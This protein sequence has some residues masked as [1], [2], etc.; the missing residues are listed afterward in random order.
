MM[1]CNVASFAASVPH[2]CPHLPLFAACWAR[3]QHDAGLCRR[4]VV[5]RGVCVCRGV[6]VGVGGGRMRAAPR[7]GA[8]LAWSPC[9]LAPTGTPTVCRGWLIF[10]PSPLVTQ[11]RQDVSPRPVAGLGHFPPQHGQPTVLCC[12]RAMLQWSGPVNAPVWDGD[13]RCTLRMLCYVHSPPCCRYCFKNAQ[14]RCDCP[15]ECSGP[16][17]TSTHCVPPPLP[18]PAARN[19]RRLHLHLGQHSCAKQ[20]LSLGIGGQT[21]CTNANATP[22]P[23]SP[24]TAVGMTCTGGAAVSTGNWWCE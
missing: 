23:A 19:S 14:P 4:P 24:P 21:Q 9:A 13:G 5:G 2:P 8:G 10:F 20:Q 22:V 7:G 17:G 12:L 3:V 18:V 16:C 6:R 15:G 11:V 1:A